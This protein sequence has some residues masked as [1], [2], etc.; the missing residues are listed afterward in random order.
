[1]AETVDYS[2]AAAGLGSRL[3]I[4]VSFVE[5]LLMRFVILTDASQ[6]G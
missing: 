1:M 4:A 2:K 6:C 3:M 5:I